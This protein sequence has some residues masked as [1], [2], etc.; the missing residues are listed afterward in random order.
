MAPQVLKGHGHG[1]TRAFRNADEN[2]VLVSFAGHRNGLGWCRGPGPCSSLGR[3]SGIGPRSGRGRLSALGRR[4][5]P[6]RCSG[7]GRR[8]N[9]GRHSSLGGC[10]GLGRCGALGQRGGLRR[11][12]GLGHCSGTGRC[13]AGGLGIQGC[14][15]L[16]LARVTMLP[17]PRGESRRLLFEE[18][19]QG[20]ED[21]EVGLRQHHDDTAARPQL[22]ERLLR[23]QAPGPGCV[24]QDEQPPPLPGELEPRRRHRGPQPVQRGHRVGVQDGPKRRVDFIVRI[25]IDYPPQPCM[26]GGISPER[27]IHREVALRGVLLRPRRQA[28]AQ[29]RGQAIVHLLLVEGVGDVRLLNQPAEPLVE[30][31]VRRRLRWR[32]VATRPGPVRQG[33]PPLPLVG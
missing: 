21:L 28:G 33:L 7:P 23:L 5:S 20:S 27:R 8:S 25:R 1:S 6:R 10:D 9:L 18:L 32:R 2:G 14:E 17:E 4:S 22:I 3:V 31:R 30:A 29:Q 16:R 15:Q 26:Q 12:G 11:C 13:D 19:L 24:A